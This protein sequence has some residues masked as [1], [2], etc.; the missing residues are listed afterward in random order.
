MTA[1]NAKRIEE[2]RSLVVAGWIERD[3]A[4]ELRTS[5]KAIQIKIARL[6]FS[7][8]RPIV[9]E[10]PTYVP[11][12]TLA[13]ELVTHP[14]ARKYPPLNVR[15]GDAEELQCRW[16]IGDA[17]GADTIICGQPAFYRSWCPYHH[18]VGRL[19]HA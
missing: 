11:L 6:G 3:I 4:L 10:E 12:P 19:H 9:R 16:I 17:N 5:V 2:L 15:L 8:L 1:W 18:V 13:P 7:A 14:L